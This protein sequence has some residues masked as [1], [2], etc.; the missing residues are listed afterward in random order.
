MVPR[1]WSTDQSATNEAAVVEWELGYVLRMPNP[2][3]ALAPLLCGLQLVL[4]PTMIEP[5]WKTLQTL[6]KDMSAV[7]QRLTTGPLLQGVALQ[8]V[9]QV[10]CPL[11]VKDF[12]GTSGA[13]ARCAPWLHSQLSRLINSRN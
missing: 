3:L 6:T 13:G 2:P 9:A 1:S 5:N 12:E 11:Q 7:V 10:I 8:R 4:Q